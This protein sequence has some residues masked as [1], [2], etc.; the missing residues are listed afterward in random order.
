MSFYEEIELSRDM[1]NQNIAD[2]EDEIIA[3]EAIFP[4]EFFVDESEDS[5]NASNA[6]DTA[7]SVAVGRT[8]KCMSLLIT[9]NLGSSGVQIVTSTCDSDGKRL[10]PNTPA[11]TNGQAT[12]GDTGSTPASVS[13]TATYDLDFLPPIRLCWR[14]PPEYPS[15]A[16]PSFA[17]SCAWLGPVALAAA[18][19][20]LDRIAEAAA[21]APRAHLPP[22]ARA[23]TITAALSYVWRVAVG[24]RC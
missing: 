4:D 5:D 7:V 17:I 16:A 1:I 8:G 13:T 6:A 23:S 9:A 22:I 2:Q 18:C 21:G 12:N 11:E 10:A 20:E 15:H 19:E 3:L 14:C 24:S